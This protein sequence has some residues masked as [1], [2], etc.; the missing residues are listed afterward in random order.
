MTMRIDVNGL[1]LTYGDVAALDNLSLSLEGNKI[2]GLLGRNG[3]GKTTLLSV[4]AAF[5]QQTSGEVQINGQPVFENPAITS[6]IAL[7]RETGAPVYDD[8]KVEE[9]LR[10]AAYLR[11]TWDASYAEQLIERFEIPTKIKVSQLSRGKR[12]AFG[13]VLGLASRAPLTMFDETHLGMD[14]PSRYA[15][16]D[17]LLNDYMAQPRAFII[18]TH[19]I[20]EVSSLFEEVVIIDEGR[21]VVHDET[22]ALLSRGVAITGPAD[23]VDRHVD[24]LTVIGEKQLGR[25]K[26]VMVY[27][28]LDDAQRQRAK[29]DQLDLEAIALQ[30]LFVHLTTQRGDDA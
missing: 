7:V 2:F 17:E 9:A 20:E 11:S 13:I 12:A 16:Y 27:G 22:E 21:L 14:A 29:A 6:Q 24:G 10:Y 30:D 8:D 26:S 3:S 1:R 25:T 18:S 19:L 28:D 4:L 23:A 5:R 15:F